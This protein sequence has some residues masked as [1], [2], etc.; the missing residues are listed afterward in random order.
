[1]VL[2]MSILEEDAPI[3]HPIS[4]SNASLKV[5]Q[6]RSYGDSHEDDARS[7]ISLSTDKGMVFANFNSDREIKDR[8]NFVSNKDSRFRAS[9]FQNQLD[10][11]TPA[12]LSHLSLGSFRIEDSH[13]VSLPDRRSVRSPTEPPRRKSHLFTSKLSLRPRRSVNNIDTKYLRAIGDKV[14]YLHHDTLRQNE[15]TDRKLRGLLKKH[16]IKKKRTFEMTDIIKK[17]K[18]SQSQTFY[19]RKE[20]I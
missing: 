17:L 13:N 20:K 19:M 16:A 9:R 12:N 5:A 14:E 10:K 1:M 3:D 18:Q 11:L 8:N 2:L 4:F 6:I 15:T 7:S